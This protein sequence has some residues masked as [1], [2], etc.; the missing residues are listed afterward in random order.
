MVFESCEEWFLFLF[1]EQLGCPG[2]EYLSGDRVTLPWDKTVVDGEPAR[3]HR[4]NHS[5]QVGSLPDGVSEG[6][7]LGELRR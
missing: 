6:V 7:A 2:G 1:R 3:G 5:L 4:L